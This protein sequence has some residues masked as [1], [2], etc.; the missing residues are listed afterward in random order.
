MRYC[1]NKI[2]NIKSF[3]VDHIQLANG[4]TND[5]ENLKVLCKPCHFEKSKQEA[6][7]GY[8]KLSETAS[9]F[10]KT[11]L[12]IFNSNLCASRAFV[13]HVKDPKTLP[14]KQRDNKIFHYDINKCR[15]NCLRYN[16]YDFPLFTVM[17][18][19]KPYHGSKLK[20]GLYYVETESYFPLRGNGWYSQPMIEFCLS[21]EYIAKQHIKYVLESSLAIPSN[22]FN[23]FIDYCYNQLGDFAKLSINSMIGCF[24]PKERENWRTL[25]ISSDPNECFY[26][27]LKNNGCFIESRDINDKTYFQVY[28]RYFSS[29]DETEAPIY[30]MI[31]DLEAIELKK[32]SNIITE[33]Q[34]TIIDLST[35]CVSAVF[36][37]N[38]QPFKLDGV[39]VVGY[40][41]DTK[42]EVPCYKI[43]EEE[44]RLNHEQLAN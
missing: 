14:K 36:P 44:T 35:D 18:Q 33:H 2:V 11:T 9:S 13:E 22:Y 42:K 43:E 30:N 12:D 16:K 7:E 3:H 37:D 5:D 20:P 34:G 26:Y 21:Q 15:K 38:N 25:L 39:N 29:K 32:L 17:D 8:V 6:E 27:Y 19:P 28:D 23:E 24:K 10:N 4:G 41:F 1:C 40:Y 31:L